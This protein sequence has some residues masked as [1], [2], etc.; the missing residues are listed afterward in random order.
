MKN[1]MFTPAGFKGTAIVA[2][3][4]VLTV[5]AGCAT[6]STVTSSVPSVPRSSF[7]HVHGVGF[8]ERSA[9]VY[10]ATHEGLSTVP[11]PVGFSLH[12]AAL[13]GPIDGLRQDNLQ[14][15]RDGERLYPFRQPAP[16]VFSDADRGLVS[17]A[18]RG[19]GWSVVAPVL[20]VVHQ[21]GIV[22]SSHFGATWRIL[23]MN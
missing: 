1:P 17:S 12:F 19:T 6:V 21:R 4:L 15:A 11:D 5:L 7:G 8:D 2:G 18:D 9:A 13:G 22:A 23:V 16:T 14:F 3:L 10:I 20:V